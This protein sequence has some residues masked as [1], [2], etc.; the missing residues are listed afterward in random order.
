M[1]LFWLRSDLRHLDNTALSAAAA[2]G[3]TLAVYVISPQQWLMHDD[4]V[5]KLNRKAR[6]FHL[7]RWLFVL[8][9]IRSS[10]MA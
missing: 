5:D 8:V 4:E 3:P 9:F 7:W 1:Q 6:R 10:F 2:R